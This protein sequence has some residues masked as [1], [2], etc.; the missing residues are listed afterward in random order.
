VKTKSI[1]S[2]ISSTLEIAGAGVFIAPSK[3]PAVAPTDRKSA[4]TG[5]IR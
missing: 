4:L 1:S 5:Q 3:K 2:L